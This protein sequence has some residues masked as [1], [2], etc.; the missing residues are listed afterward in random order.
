M[1]LI[2]DIPEWLYEECKRE[3]Y[4][5]TLRAIIAIGVPCEPKKEEIKKNEN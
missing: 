4:T 3:R 5:E 2:I 1:K